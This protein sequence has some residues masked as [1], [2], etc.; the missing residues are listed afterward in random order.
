LKF[1]STSLHLERK[2]KELQQTLS[3][4]SET[5]TSCS[6]PY[7]LSC[8]TTTPDDRTEP[9]ICNPILKLCTRPHAHLW[10]WFKAE[11]GSHTYPKYREQK[12]SPASQMS[13]TPSRRGCGASRKNEGIGV[14]FSPRPEGLRARIL[15]NVSP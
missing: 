15:S 1:L 5:Q 7:R 9:T 6:A 8:E 2:E 14:C 4:K 12:I 13:F 3:L 11:S 10:K